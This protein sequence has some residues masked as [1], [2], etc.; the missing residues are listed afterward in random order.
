MKALIVFLA[1]IVLLLCTF[2]FLVN[3]SISFP[4]QFSKFEIEF[5]PII[6]IAT[7]VIAFASLFIVFFGFK[8]TTNA[9]WGWLLL[10]SS[11]L[12]LSLAFIH[13]YGF[14]KPDSTWMFSCGYSLVILVAVSSVTTN[15]QHQNVGNLVE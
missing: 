3:G 4:L 10:L 7:F 5:Q 15:R 8:F 14:H 11:F 1:A 2:S 9:F 6:K 12:I 13:L